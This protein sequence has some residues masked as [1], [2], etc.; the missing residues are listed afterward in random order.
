MLSFVVSFVSSFSTAIE[1]IQ[2]L[3]ER[4]EGILKTK[5]TMKGLWEGL[6]N[7]RSF[8]GLTG[9][10]VKT[11]GPGEFKVATGVTPWGLSKAFERPLRYIL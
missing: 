3:C 7:T 2:V 11:G 4:F 5:E 8:D 6:S 9:S 1:A 10:P